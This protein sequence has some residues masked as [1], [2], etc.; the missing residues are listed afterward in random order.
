MSLR[1]EQYRALHD[2]LRLLM[3]IHRQDVKLGEL[4]DRAYN[5]LRHYPLLDERGEP[6]FS[7]DPFECPI[8]NQP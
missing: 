1:Y 6:M 5:C 2:T 3:D 7:N 8:I 4:K